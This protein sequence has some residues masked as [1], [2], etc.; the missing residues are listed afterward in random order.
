MAFYFP[1]L[2]ENSQVLWPRTAGNSDVQLADA[3]LDFAESSHVMISSP[4]HSLLFTTRVSCDGTIQE[5][6]G[7]PCRIYSVQ[8]WVESLC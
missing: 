2:D 7:K 5:E 1:V 6:L 8:K 4:N 3:K